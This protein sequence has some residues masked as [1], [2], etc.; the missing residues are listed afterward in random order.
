MTLTPKAAPA[1][2]PGPAESL[3]KRAVAPPTTLVLSGVK[4]VARP[5]APLHVFLNLPQGVEPELLSPYHVGILNL[6]KFETGSGG[7]HT[8]HG[9]VQAP[10]DEFTFH[11]ADLLARQRSAGIWDGGAISVAVT[12]L[13]VDGPTDKIYVTIEKVSI[14]P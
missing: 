7:A 1:P 11:V 4:L 6:F 5:P 10:T 14:R 9:T 8:G 13:G 12:T 3:A 2:A